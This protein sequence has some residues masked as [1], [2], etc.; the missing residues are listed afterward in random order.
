LCL[1]PAIYFFFVFLAVVFL[2]FICAFGH[3]RI[4]LADF[5]NVA[6]F[7]VGASFDMRLAGG[8]PQ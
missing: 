4:K 7:V 2:V 3:D 5:D 8:P 6:F 1:S